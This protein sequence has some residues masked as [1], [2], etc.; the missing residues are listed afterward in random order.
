MSIKFKILLVVLAL[1]VPQMLC[2]DAGTA[3]MWTSAFHLLI[4]NFLIGVGEGFILKSILKEKANR[5]VLW[6]ILS[7]YTSWIFGIFLVG[8]FQNQ[9][10]DM[11]FDLENILSFWWL[12]MVILFFLTFVVEI[13]FFYLSLKKE[14]RNLKISAKYSFLI[15]AVS[16]L[17]LLIMYV[18][19]S[20]FSLISNTKF[21]P[22]IVNKFGKIELFLL[23]SDKVLKTRLELPL[24][25][26]IISK[27]KNGNQF[28]H[29][30]LKKDSIEQKYD[31][32]IESEESDNSVACP[33]F[34][35]LL[36][37]SYYNFKSWNPGELENVMFKSGN[38]NELTANYAGYGSFSIQNGNERISSYGLNIPWLNL[39]AHSFSILSSRE[40]LFILD[41]RLVLMDIE[42]KEIAYITRANSYSIRKLE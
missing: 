19:V 5:P 23:T 30:Y 14:Y 35:S 17:A 11:I 15:N 37:T 3:L 40:I 27:V 38:S 2:A 7:N 28:H 21:N 39:N 6:L 32:M 36:D 8:F 9:A 33:N 31:L 16:Y 29:F 12:S 1:L 25:E 20:D 13:P 26:E 34:I 41:G 18:N 42:T 24:R 4:L 10:I 22:K